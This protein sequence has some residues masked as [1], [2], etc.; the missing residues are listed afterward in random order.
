MTS[1][2]INYFAVFSTTDKA[3]VWHKKLLEAIDIK[4][5][6]TPEKADYILV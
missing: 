6:D 1:H 4:L 3:R 5:V 2:S